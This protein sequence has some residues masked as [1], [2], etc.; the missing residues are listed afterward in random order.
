M[1]DV[2]KQSQDMVLARVEHM[3]VVHSEKV[4]LQAG[5]EEKFIGLIASVG[6]LTQQAELVQGE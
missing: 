4:H 5:L 6:V 3:L 1:V 2:S